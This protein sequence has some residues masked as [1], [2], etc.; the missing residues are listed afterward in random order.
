MCRFVTT[1]GLNGIR[2][3]EVSRWTSADVSSFVTKVTGRESYGQLFLNEEID[4]EAFL[5]LSQ[6]DISNVLNIKL[7][8]TLKIHGAILYALTNE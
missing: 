7:G 1:V 8:P 4:G 3:S 5:L 2:G 6:N